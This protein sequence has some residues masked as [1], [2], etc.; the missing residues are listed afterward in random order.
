MTIG[1][2]GASLLFGVESPVYNAADIPPV[3]VLDSNLRFMGGLGLGLGLS[4]LWIL[5][6]IEKQVMIFRLIWLCALLGGVGRLVSL[7]QVGVPPLPLIVFA[8]IEVP[9]VPLLIYWQYRV[10]RAQEVQV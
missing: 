7:A 2:G 5:P 3:P 6:T 9:G 10:S 8:A 4:L 1:L